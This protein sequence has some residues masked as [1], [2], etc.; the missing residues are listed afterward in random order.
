MKKTIVHLMVL[1]VP[2]FAASGNAQT[3]Y[4]NTLSDESDGDTSSI[5]PVRS[6]I[7]LSKDFN[8]PMDRSPGFRSHPCD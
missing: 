7:L 3:I 1:L 2:L 4:V 6:S 5:T 8:L